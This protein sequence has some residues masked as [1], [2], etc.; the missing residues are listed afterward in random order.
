VSA[1]SKR[2]RRH[3]RNAKFWRFTMNELRMAGR[4]SSQLVESKLFRRARDIEERTDLAKMLAT[5]E[6]LKPTPKTDAERFVDQ[7]L[8]S[9]GVYAHPTTAAKVRAEFAELG[10]TVVSHA[11]LEPGQL[12][13]EPEATPFYVPLPT[14]FR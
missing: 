3:A 5:I 6:A 4:E 14:R 13:A 1:A 11:L 7:A 2:R 9:R 8:R 12:L 10:V